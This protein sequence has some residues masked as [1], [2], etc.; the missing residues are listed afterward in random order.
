M[1]NITLRKIKWK[2]LYIVRTFFYLFGKNW[3]DFY[4][5][6]LDYQ[7]R[8]INL[9]MILSNTLSPSRYKGLWDWNRGEYFLKYLK[10]HGFEGKH[11]IF[12]LGSG[13]GRATIPIL[14]FLNKDGLY[15]GSEISKRRITLTED[16]IKKENLNSK[17]YKLYFSKDNNLNFLE[18]NSLDFVWVFSVFNHMPDS[19]IEV[20]IQSLFMKMKKNALLF[21]YFITPE[22][23]STS[24][25]TFSRTEKYMEELF[26]TIGFTFDKMD[27]YDDDY[28]EENKAK[29]SRMYIVKK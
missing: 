13:Y 12:D 1:K 27:D 5:W 7:D 14:K 19:V 11:T 3:N 8:K 24:V 10:R 25:N 2:L 28:K 22:N 23:E 20:I 18:N 4:A 21:A 16:W 29:Y 9:N 15:I 26:T 17:N 6:M